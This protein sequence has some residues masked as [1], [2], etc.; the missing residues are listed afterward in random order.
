MFVAPSILETSNDGTY[1]S[2]F[3][4][5]SKALGY[6]D[7][8]S[9]V[10]SG[11]TTVNIYLLGGDDHYMTRSYGDIHYPNSQ[12]NDNSFNQEVTIQPAFCGQTLGGHVFT[13]GDADCIPTTDQITVYYKMGNSYRF[14]VPKKL[15]VIS[16]LFDALDSSIDTLEDWLDESAPCWELSGTI[17][18]IS[19]SA[20]SPPANWDIQ[21]P[22]TEQCKI[23]FGYSFFQFGF[24]DSSEISSVGTLTITS[25]TFQHFFYDFTSLIGLN[26][27]HGHIV[28]SDST[29]DKFSNCGSI[30][31]DTRE[32]PELNYGNISNSN[33]IKVSYRS[34]QY[35][36]DV[37]ENKIIHTQ[38]TACSDALWA[39]IDISTSTFTNFNYM[40]GDADGLHSI[41]STSN[42]LHQGII[43]NLEQFYGNIAVYNNEF[44][45]LK[46]TY[47]SWED[48]Y[49]DEE[50]YETD[51]NWIKSGTDLKQ[52]KT[53]IFVKTKTGQVEIYGNTFSGWSSLFGLVWISREADSTAPV[54][55]HQNTFSQNS[56]IIAGANAIRIDLFHTDDYQENL[57][58]S[59]MIW[60][61]V[62]ISNNTFTKNVGCFSTVGVIQ[63]NWYNSDYVDYPQSAQYQYVAINPMNNYFG[64]N[65]QKDDVV[66]FSIENDV[67][68][69]SSGEAMDLNKFELYQNTYDQNFIGYTKTVVDIQGVRRIHIDGEVYKNN[70]GIYKEALEMY[71]QFTTVGK[72]DAFQRKPGAFYFR[73]Y[74]IGDSD[75]DSLKIIAEATRQEYYPDG[76]LRIDGAFYVQI[77]NTTFSNNAFPEAATT[78]VTSYYRSN[79]IILTRWQ[80]EVYLNDL[81][82]K[83][84]QGLDLTNLETILGATEY[85]KLKTAAPT[86]RDAVGQ[87]TTSIYA[88]DFLIDYAFKNPLILLVDPTTNTNSIF[89][90]YFDAFAIDGLILSNITHYNPGVSA[91]PILKVSDDVYDFT[92]KNIDIDDFDSIR[93]ELSMFYLVPYDTLTIQEG[94]VNNLNLKAYNLDTSLGEYLP[95]KGSLFTMNSVKLNGGYNDFVYSVSNFVLDTIHAKIGGAFYLSVE[96]T[97]SLYAQACT[98]T[99]SNVTFQNSKSISSGLVYSDDNN[100]SIIIT[101]CTFTGN[102]GLFGEADLYYS[103]STSFGISDTTFT[104]FTSDSSMTVGQSITLKM[105]TPLLTY[106][107]MSNVTFKCSDT[108]YSDSSYLDL[109]SNPDALLTKRPPIMLVPG[110]LSS[111]GSTFSNCFSSNKGGVIYGDTSS[112]YSDT[113]STFKENA[114]GSGGAIYALSTTLT[115]TNTLFTYNYANNGGSLNLDSSTT[116][117]GFTGVSCTY[118]KVYTNGGCLYMTASSKITMVDSTFAYNTAYGQA[119]ALY[120]LGTGASTI[121][122][123]TFNNNVANGGNTISLLFAV[124]T[125][126]SVTMKDNLAYV[127]SNGIFITF[128]TVTIENSTFTNTV[129]PYGITDIITA[130][131]NS[132]TSGWFISVSAGATVII[133]TSTFSKGFS[134]I[135]GHMH[136]SGNSDVTITNTTF[137]LSQVQ[138]NGGAIYA[139]SFSV[140]TIT[141]WTFLTCDSDD[142]GSILYLSAGKTVITSS[143]FT[144]EPGH[145]AIY[146]AGGNLTATSITISNSSPT[147]ISSDSEILGGAIFVSN[148]VNF[149]VI[150]STIRDLRYAYQGG[151]IYVSMT[152]AFRDTDTNYVLK[153]KLTSTNFTSNSANYGGAVYFDDI[154]YAEI[155][156]W[157]FTNNT[158]LT[159]YD[160]EGAQIGGEGGAFYYKSTSST[161]SKA[162][163]ETGNEF[164]SNY[165]GSAGGALF[166][167]FNQP[168]NISLLTFSSNTAEHYGGDKAW[169]AQLIK[170][171]TEADYNSAIQRRNL[172]TLT[173]DTS[174]TLT[175]Q[176]SGGTIENIYLALYDE[177]G[178]IVMSDFTST[179]SLS[180]S[181]N[182]AGDTYT[183]TLTGTTSVTV[184]NGV[185]EFDGLTFTAEPGESYTL[186]FTTTGIDITKPSN[187][188][189][190]ASISKS[191]SA[192][193]FSISLR[194]CLKGEAFSSSGA[195]VE[196]EEDTEYSLSTLTTVGNC[197]E[198]QTQRMYCNGGADIGPKPGYWR[199]SEESDNFIKWLLESSWLGYVSPSNN[200]LGEWFTGYQRIL[201]ADWEVGY[202]RTGEFECSK[203]PLFIWNVLRLAGVGIAITFGLVIMIR[204][205]L[206]G[207]LQRKNVQSVY[208]KILMNHLQLITLTASFDFDW[209]ERVLKIFDTTKPVAEVSTQFL[210][211]DCFLDQ[212]NSGDTD[213]NLV[214]LYYQKM[215]MYG[216]LPLF[217]GLGSVLFWSLYFCKKKNQIKAKRNARMIA[218]LII[219]FFLVHPTIVEYMFSNFNCMDIDEEK[220]VVRDLEVECWKSEHINYS[221]MIAVPSLIIWGFGIPAFAWFILARNKEDLDLLEV[222][223]RYGFLYNGY[224]KQFYFWE[225]VNMYR[226]ITIIFISVFLKV[227]GIIT[228]A[229][230][231]FI[232][233]I[234]FLILNLKL[235][236]YTFQALNDMEMMSIITCMLTIYCGLFFLS[237][238]PEV[239]QSDDSSVQE[240]DNGCKYYFI[241][242]NL[243]VRLNEGSKIFFFLIIL[244]ANISFAIYWAYKM[245]EEVKNTMRTKL[246]KFYLY[247]F[248]WNNKRKFE[249]EKRR[250]AIQDENDILKEEF[251]S[252]L[253]ALK[254]LYDTGKV[255]LNKVNIQKIGLYLAPKNFLKAIEEKKGMNDAEKKRLMK[256]KRKYE[257]ERMHQNLVGDSQYETIDQE[258]HLEV[259]KNRTENFMNE[260]PISPS[261]EAKIHKFL[262]LPNINRGYKKPMS[263][264]SSIKSDEEEEDE[265]NGFAKHHNSNKVRHDYEL[266]IS[267]PKKKKKPSTLDINNL[268][269][270]I[271]NNESILSPSSGMKINKDFNK[272]QSLKTPIE[273]SITQDAE[274][275]GIVAPRLNYINPFNPKEESKSTG[276]N[277]DDNLLPNSGKNTRKNSKSVANNTI[278]EEEMDD[279]P[280][281]NE[282]QQEEYLK[283]ERELRRKHKISKAANTNI[284]IGNFMDDHNLKN[285]KKIDRIKKI[286]EDRQKNLSKLRDKELVIDL[287]N[288]DFFGNSVDAHKDVAASS[289]KLI[290]EEEEND[291]IKIQEF[292]VMSEGDAY[293]DDELE[294]SIDERVD[295]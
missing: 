23:T 235:M 216:A 274:E 54:L 100:H 183:P 86:E 281:I 249:E 169:F 265:N 229:L 239:Y 4:Q 244:L 105:E 95:N 166:W 88:P 237:D 104:L 263:D 207:A 273:R 7:E 240:A 44:T 51:Y 293:Y 74:Y 38:P 191:T 58:G 215:T 43:L 28:I 135:G 152:K 91:A 186:S 246:G 205:T 260:P 147:S 9:S 291:Q 112:E 76:I 220:R 72:L 64:G 267:N 121:N 108:A 94:T 32:Y 184:T 148:P 178:Q 155:K 248:L 153:V 264:N 34:S 18:G 2:P 92:L 193:S 271:E 35:S 46:F 251:D 30:I 70:M 55:I 269:P 242:V 56:A 288:I 143:A 279:E 211:F 6:A 10:Y 102:Y 232:V 73:N 224:K 163:F 41:L 278:E 172:G 187:I 226:K 45:G 206:A 134:V 280:E 175:S 292:K 290:N 219:L 159:G 227:A 222:R 266:P 118:N 117:Y 125:L 295:F 130:A 261:Y 101:N 14:T 231:I 170:K 180:I 283:A 59:A 115:F 122:N 84:Y 165:A 66:N 26:N 37:T 79:G 124:T 31:R 158:A 119:S 61:G 1:A 179:I 50:A 196:W 39:S 230:V 29:F 48:I 282:E 154:N 36:S 209:P 218:T 177:F 243:I 69:A 21:S 67:T 164:T 145:T 109:V 106:I 90:N 116:V 270:E 65:I 40:K 128:S 77:D 19:P 114:A 277:G 157:I 162:V 217:L 82:F 256:I 189:Y 250:R 262:G 201:C 268:I 12:R 289:E 185:V 33:R 195:C 132:Y 223:E 275:L 49:N 15:T 25:W 138:T 210:S 247:I 141:D 120:S 257:G 13:A 52:G 202:S 42:M 127:D 11:T 146:V 110:R 228:Q 96:S 98:L 234:I 16:I 140:L 57:S 253:D 93:G 190:L 63:A 161:K 107:S 286:K 168:K 294:E 83:D 236:P 194:S 221:M 208:I 176:Q 255:V 173:G 272:K 149:E 150:S 53:L 47:K 123:C 284:K 192:M 142:N 199:S 203:C 212:R 137:G 144:A 62:K 22:Q 89:Q 111:T 87:E 24:T 97:V 17:M 68:L 259:S 213:G 20:I 238:L 258:D 129:Y 160:D 113:G 171:I 78:S 5:I 3:G 181:G 99:I 156:S 85:A 103:Y 252:N 188:V 198:C 225:S 233:L 167:N 214:R 200:N 75:A 285:Y 139:S 182:H 8:Y 126:T 133:T 71:G 174:L 241:I 131:Y 204:S 60:A 245:I 254:K 136:I 80:G 27:G 151:A 81:T 197:K 276:D 287:D